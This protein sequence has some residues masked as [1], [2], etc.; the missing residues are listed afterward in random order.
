MFA[1]TCNSST[2]SIYCRCERGAEG[3]GAPH[4]DVNM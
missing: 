4:T 3:G 2:S 1:Y